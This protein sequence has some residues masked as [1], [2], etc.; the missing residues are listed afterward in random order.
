MRRQIDSVVVGTVDLG[1]P[2]RFD[3]FSCEIATVRRVDRVETARGVPAVWPR[4]R[5][6]AAPNCRA[7]CFGSVGGDFKGPPISRVGKEAPSHLER[8]ASDPHR[9]RPA[10]PEPCH[11]LR[12]QRSLTCPCL[13]AARPPRMCASHFAWPSV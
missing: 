11:W 12:S 8:R 7:L 5:P 3:R 6:Q 4:R 2:P 13:S 10:F 9:K 1:G